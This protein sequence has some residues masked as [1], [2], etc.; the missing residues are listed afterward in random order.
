[1]KYQTCQNGIKMVWKKDK[2]ERTLT[3]FDMLQNYISSP[4]TIFLGVFFC[5][6]FQELLKHILYIIFIIKGSYYLSFF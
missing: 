5:S 4:A 2:T 1:M 3:V 6:F